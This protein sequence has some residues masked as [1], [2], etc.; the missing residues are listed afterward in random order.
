MA[1][2]K[3]LEQIQEQIV[4]LANADFS[5]QGELSDKGDDLDSVIVGLN[6]L[7]EELESYTLQLKESEERLTNTLQQLTN[8]QHLSHIGSWEWN[9]AD[10]T[11]EWTEELYRIYGRDRETFEASFENFIACI[12]PAD[13][14][15]VSDVIQQGFKNKEPFSF[16][17][18]VAR[19]DGIEKILDCKGDVHLDENGELKRMTGTAQDV[20][21]L[22]KAEEKIVQLAAIVESSN[23]AIVG[24]TV[25]GYI[26]SWNRKAEVLFGYTEAEVVGKPSTF[27]FPPDRIEEEAAVLRQVISGGSLVGFETE[28]KKKDGTVFPI[29]ATYSVIKDGTGKVMGISTF[30][31]DITEKKQAEE[32]IMQLAA[33]VES[34]RDAIISKTVDG[35]ITSWNKQAEVLFGYKESEILGQHISTLFPPDRLDE[36]ALI[37]QKITSGEALL[38]FETQRRRKDGS[39][40]PVAATISAINDP[41]GR[42]IGISNIIRDITEK[43]Q[44]EARLQAYTTALEQKNHESEQFAYIAS[45]DLQEPLRTIT[46]FIGIFSEEYIDKLDENAATYL[47]F[48]SSASNRMQTL[49]TDLLE[50]TTIEND[51]KWVE[52][53]CNTL[54]SDI[55]QDLSATISE[56]GTTVQ[57]DNLPVIT[58]Q[59]TRFKSLFQNLISNAIKFRK[60]D[61][62][63]VIEISAEDNDREWLFEIKDNGI[64]IDK[65]YYEKV[66]KLFQ[67]LHGRKEYEGTGIGLAHCKKIV[68][69]RGGRIWVESEPGVG[70]SF[71]FTVPKTYHL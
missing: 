44:A 29:A 10:N 27:L 1:E 20:T 18:R 11:V 30:I 66:F 39:V 40:F 2:D 67:R 37:L 32:K 9:I 53:D 48:I 55:L 6:L 59:E 71:Y 61:E 63:P 7:G 17:H 5:T 14:Q 22:R 28:R 4:R 49:I 64:G 31:R 42:M 25:D 54:V 65:P 68:D 51:R 24:K 12:H 70:S 33:I 13:R 15:Y 47:K 43:K 62:A 19:P 26:T 52:I 8:A 56:T 35:Y 16:T 69:L 50:Y 45:H 58:G 41:R 60:K 46:N 34:S 38:N 21:E 57:Y 23:E 3:R 36:E